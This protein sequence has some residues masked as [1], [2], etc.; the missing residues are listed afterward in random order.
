MEV[1]WLPRGEVEYRVRRGCSARE[2]PKNCF[3]GSTDLLQYKDCQESCNVVE[4]GNGCNNGLLSVAQRF[5]PENGGVSS[6]K[7]CSY[8]QNQDGSVNGNLNCKENP[9]SVIEQDCPL[10]AS[11]ACYEAS[12][13]HKSYGGIGPGEVE[14]DYRG[15][16]TFE[17]PVE[18]E[19]SE[20]AANCVSVE[21]NGLAHQNCKRTCTGDNCN[22]HRL[23]N[24]HTCY[25]C[26][27]TRNAQGEKIGVGD[28]RCFE[29][30]SGNSLVD[31]E[32]GEDYCFDEMV[33]D[34]LPRGDQVTRII[35]GCSKTP[36]GECQ[37]NDL[38]MTAYKDC[39]HS[40]VGDRCN[41][42]FEV[43]KKFRPNDRRT[44]E[45]QACQYIEYD[46]GDLVGNQ[47]CK[48]KTGPNEVNNFQY[49]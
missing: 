1:D 38:P 29:N 2:A 41:D 25:Q 6:C 18:D 11:T 19:T 15:C 43:A 12:S 49:E 23:Q 31:C 5:A 3:E 32:E 4:D 45:C 48:D 46:N 26:T 14:D 42:N 9:D 7:A 20:T 33:I 24:R 17:L 47:F 8:F 30:P 21:V 22:V 39:Y 16:S 10:Y 37:G 35:R 28:D 36:A 13:F 27:A 34:W 40:C 44:F